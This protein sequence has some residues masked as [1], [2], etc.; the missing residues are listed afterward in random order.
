MLQDVDIDQA[1]VA[2]E[3]TESHTA[4]TDAASSGDARQSRRR[5]T[6]LIDGRQ[7][8]GVSAYGMP[9]K[10]AVPRTVTMRDDDRIGKPRATSRLRHPIESRRFGSI[11]GRQ[12][13]RRAGRGRDGCREGNQE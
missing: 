2:Q 10:P 6:G 9:E 13:L 5:H 7:D 4:E 12:P 3:R 11:D 8:G 1:G